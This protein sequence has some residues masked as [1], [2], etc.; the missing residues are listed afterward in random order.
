M[1]NCKKNTKMKKR[2]ELN[3]EMEHQHSLRCKAF[4]II[5]FQILLVDSILILI[6]S[7]ISQFAEKHTF[8]S[9]NVISMKLLAYS[10]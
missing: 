5:L 10:S 3:S 1:K 6:D 4:E 2:V 8:S 9:E 7:I